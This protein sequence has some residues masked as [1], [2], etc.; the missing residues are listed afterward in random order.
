V[1]GP[2]VSVVVPTYQNESYVGEALESAL[3]QT[4]PYLE[5]VV[6]DHS[7]TDQTWEI[8]SRIAVNPK[9]RVMRTAAGGGAARNWNRVTAEANGEYVKLL[10]ADDLL[11]PTCIEEQV[12]AA[13]ANPDVVLVA[14]KRDIIDARG[15]ALVRS[16]GLA[17]LDGVVPGDV[18]IRRMIRAGT[19]LLGEP[20]CVLFRTR[21]LRDAG[22]WAG[23]QAYLIDEDM[24]VRVLQRGSL[25]AVRRTLA[26]FRISESQWSVSL[27]RSQARQ[28]AALHRRLR[29]ER[30]DII[31]GV[32]EWVGSRRA[33][34]IAWM[35]RL[36][37]VA[38]ARRMRP[39]RP[40]A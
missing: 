24:Y 7:S 28:A 11:G 34:A 27:A 5:V 23:D 2:L 18:A 12:R 4:Y 35:R 3:S 30:P 19:N 1:T 14:A 33:T 38:W 32:D 6:A 20:A 15:A 9:V 8:V 29:Q 16:R 17:D 22:G 21:T 36:A 13:E 37:Y 31:S 25:F 40:V 10:C 39:S 26:A